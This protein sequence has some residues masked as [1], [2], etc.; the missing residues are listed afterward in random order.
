MEAFATI[1][2]GWGV[3]DQFYKQQVWSD[4]GFKS[5]EDFVQRSYVEDGFGSADARDLL[6]QLSVWRSSRG[7]GAPS[8]AELSAVRARVLLMPCSQDRYFGVDEISAHEAALIPHAMLAQIDS[9]WGHRAG[10]PSRPGQEADLAAL[11]TCV[12]T[13]LTQS[14]SVLSNS[15]L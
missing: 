4:L 2:A 11:R 3:G 14:K 9:A 6:A 1:Y 15:N 8:D 7:D 12:G 13:F 5:V 10:D